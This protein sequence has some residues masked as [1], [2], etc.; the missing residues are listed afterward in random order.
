MKQDLKTTLAN[1]ALANW[2]KILNPKVEILSGG[3]INWTF[4]VQTHSGKWVL[5]R[6]NPIFDPSINEDIAAV[7]E[8]LLKRNITTPT[9]TLTR[10]GTHFAR[11]DGAIWRLMSFVE[12][13]SCS[14]TNEPDVLFS[15]SKLIARFHEALASLEYKFQGIRKN[16][17]DIPLRIQQLKHAIRIHFGH[18]RIKDVQSFGQRVIDDAENLVGLSTLPKRNCHG[19]L[20]LSN[21]MLD[22]KNRAIALVDLDTV[23]PMIWPYEMG[24]ALRSWCN[25]AGEDVRQAEFSKKLFQSALEGY[26]IECPKFLTEIEKKSLLDG[27]KTICL[28]LSA[29]FLTDVLEN[30]Y[31]GWNPEKF[32]SRSEHNF[33]RAQGQY[34]L[35]KSIMAQEK[36][37]LSAQC[38]VLY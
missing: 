30:Y 3:L 14:S 12:G 32:G 19:D 37:L 38:K 15:S 17:H 1:Q 5:Q 33:T 35:Y 21:I 26:A 22:A 20:K 11:A 29:R 4:L 31:F 24:D 10:N 28:E 8:H 13:R 16:V 6:I 34:S 25:P 9:L 27:L 36:D 23:G 7:T 18:E 2:P